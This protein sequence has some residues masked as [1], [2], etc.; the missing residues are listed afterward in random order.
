MSLAD[1]QSL[2]ERMAEHF[3]SKTIVYNGGEPTLLKNLHEYLLAARNLG[4]ANCLSTHGMFLKKRM[5]IIDQL[6][7]IAIPIDG[8]TPESN[9]I[10]RPPNGDV[11][12]SAAVEAIHLLNGSHPDLHI[13]LGTVISGRNIPNED[14]NGGKN[15]SISISNSCTVAAITIIK[16]IKIC[17]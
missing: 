1:F 16:I 9:K 11:Q 2:L 5:E 4:Y 17:S 13:K 3:G 10:M 12:F 15:F 8:A 7:A 6:S 14:C